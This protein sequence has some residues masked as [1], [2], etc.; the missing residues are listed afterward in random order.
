MCPPPPDERVAIPVA[1]KMKTPEPPLKPNSVEYVE[2]VENKFE[3][4]LYKLHVF[5]QLSRSEVSGVRLNIDA[6]Y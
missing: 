2:Y 3:I 6:R 4:S 5:K 1:P